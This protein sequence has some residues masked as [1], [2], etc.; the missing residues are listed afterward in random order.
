MAT[1]VALIIRTIDPKLYDRF[2][3]G[4]ASD[5]DVVDAIFDRPG[6]KTLRY[7]DPVVSFEA[8]VILAGLEDEI[9]KEPPL[10]TIH[11]PLWDRYRNWDRTDRELFEEEESGTVARLAE[12]KHAKEV[13]GIVERMIQQGRGESDSATQ[14]ADSNC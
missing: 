4:E 5:G 6:L 11:S 7:D 1:T 9:A 2:V 10:D 8:A 3:A 12:A 13:T 14:F